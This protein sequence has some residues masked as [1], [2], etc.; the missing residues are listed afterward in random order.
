MVSG[1]FSVVLGWW[2]RFLVI[3]GVWCVIFSLL[4]SMLGECRLCVM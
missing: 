3:V 4:G 1:F 2:C